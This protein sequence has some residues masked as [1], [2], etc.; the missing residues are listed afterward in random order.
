MTA[1]SQHYAD[2][3]AALSA[4][5]LWDFLKYFFSAT[6]Y[7]LFFSPAKNLVSLQLKGSKKNTISYT[8]KQSRSRG[9]SSDSPTDPMQCLGDN[10]FKMYPLT[11]M[12]PQESN[13][14]QAGL[15]QHNSQTSVGAP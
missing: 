10:G 3:S 9:S 6:N 14:H 13:A 1:P 11:P 5:L 8:R 12:L 4:E 15:E 2:D 7:L